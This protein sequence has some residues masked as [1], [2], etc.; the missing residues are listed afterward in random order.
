MADKNSHSHP[1]QIEAAKLYSNFSTFDRIEAFEKSF[2]IQKRNI[3]Y[4]IP[5]NYFF[6]RSTECNL[7]RR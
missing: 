3:Q 6:Y 4:Q 5:F 2:K 1:P 7:L